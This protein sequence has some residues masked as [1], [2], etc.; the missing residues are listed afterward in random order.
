MYWSSVIRVRPRTNLSLKAS[1]AARLIQVH[2]IDFLDCF[3]IVTILAREISAH[4]RTLQV[5]SDNG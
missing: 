5:N 4:G 3:Q 1:E 2:K